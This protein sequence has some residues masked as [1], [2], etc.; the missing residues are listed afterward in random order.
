VKLPVSKLPLRIAAREGSGG[1]TIK[2]AT[3][4][5]ARVGILNINRFP[6]KC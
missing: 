4:I 6:F 5:K 2:P 3:V 1:E